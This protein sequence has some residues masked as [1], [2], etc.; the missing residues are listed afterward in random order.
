MCGPKFCSMKITK[1]VRDFAASMGDNEKTAL[2]LAT[3]Q[4]GMKEMSE[5]FLKMGGEV[6]VEAD[7]V[8]KSN[9]AL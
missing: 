6:Y 8:K 2:G 9:E 5:K 4:A 1:D 3:A 7:A